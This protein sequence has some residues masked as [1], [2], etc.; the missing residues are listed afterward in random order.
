MLHPCEACAEILS[1][2]PLESRVVIP[3]D[4][5]MKFMTVSKARANLSEM[6]RWVEAG[7]EV[8]LTVR[9][10]AVAKVGRPDMSGRRRIGLDAGA[11]AVPDTFDNPINWAAPQESNQ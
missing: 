10:V 1:R 8:T 4:G 3:H 7:D 11:F 6:I 2:V 5:D 9:G